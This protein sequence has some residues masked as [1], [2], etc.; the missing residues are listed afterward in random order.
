MADPFVGTS[1]GGRSNASS[2]ASATSVASWSATT[3]MP[4]TTS[5]SSSSAASSSSSARVY[6]M[7][8]S[9]TRPFCHQ[10]GAQGVLSLDA[11]LMQKVNV[12][13]PWVAPLA[14]RILLAGHLLAAL[15]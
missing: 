11:L 14:Q 15:P 12:Q 7:A 8:C 9:Q 5:G 3:A 13:T 1:V 2:L 6:E 10:I 4:L